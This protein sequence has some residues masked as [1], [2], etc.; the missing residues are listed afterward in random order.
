MVDNRDGV[1]PDINNG[2]M[3]CQ[4]QYPSTDGVPPPESVVKFKASALKLLNQLAKDTTQ[5]A[6]RDSYDKV[7]ALV[8]EVSH[9]RAAWM[10]DV[11][12]SSTNAEYTDKLGESFSLI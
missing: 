10:A 4:V 12:V 8:E 9:L 3:R 1:R 2:L 11:I 6:K 5:Q 7:A